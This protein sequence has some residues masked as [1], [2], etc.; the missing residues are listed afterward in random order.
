VLTLHAHYQSLQP[1]LLLPLQPVTW[2]T[3]RQWQLMPHDMQRV[4]AL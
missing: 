3:Q 4:A 1:S 2:Q